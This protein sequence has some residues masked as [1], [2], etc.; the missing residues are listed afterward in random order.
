ML[1]IA[2]QIPHAANP[3]AAWQQCRLQ[4]IARLQKDRLRPARSQ[5]ERLHRAPLATLEPLAAQDPEGPSQEGGSPVAQKSARTPDQAPHRF[6]GRQ[7]LDR[8]CQVCA[9]M[10]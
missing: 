3:W 8:S 4:A 7:R 2:D 1:P 9:A 5:A 6:D 10:P